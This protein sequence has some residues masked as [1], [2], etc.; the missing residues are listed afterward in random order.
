[1]GSIGRKRTLLVSSAII[2]LCLTVIVGMT[3]ALFSDSEK[4]T[5]HLKAGKL[6]I[7][8]IRTS[9]TS[10]R[11][12]EQ[13]RLEAVTDNEHVDFTNRNDKNVFGLEKAII[14][15]LSY[16]SAEMLIQNNSKSA[17]SN[18]TFAYWIEIVYTGTTKINLADQIRVTVNENDSAILSEG[19][20]VGS[21]SSPIGVLEVNESATFNVTVEFL[22]LANNNVAQGESLAFDLVVHAV[23]YTGADSS[24]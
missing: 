2:L 4:V 20:V 6:D 15:P 10:T 8:L 17:E 21:A 14:V 7:T 5:N 18:V 23:Q 3:F 16:F 1:M 13:G 24:N 9:L 19:L 11:L 12:N 22:N